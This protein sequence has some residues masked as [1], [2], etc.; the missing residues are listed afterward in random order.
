MRYDPTKRSRPAACDG[1]D[2]T[3]GNFFDQFDQPA[4]LRGNFFDQFDNHPPAPPAA[5]PWTKYQGQAAPQAA[6]PWTKYQAAP[7]ATGPWT[8]YQA[9]PVGAGVMGAPAAPLAVPPGLPML[10]PIPPIEL[11]GASAPPA[12]SEDDGGFGSWLADVAASTADGVREGFTALPDMAVQAVD[13]APRILNLP[14]MIPGMEDAYGD[15]GTV[16]EGG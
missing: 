13:Q 7:Q 2:N 16:T 6:D 3:M 14:K 10:I 8:K 11:Q 12:E 1:R 5:G 15:V 9:A 4:T